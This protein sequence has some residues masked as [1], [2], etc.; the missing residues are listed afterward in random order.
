MQ[1][2]DG[3]IK[4]ENLNNKIWETAYVASILSDKTW[5]Q[6]MQK[7]EK[8]VVTEIQQESIQ[9]EETKTMVVKKSP[10]AKVNNPNDNKIKLE[11]NQIG[12]RI[13]LLENELKNKEKIFN[14]IKKEKE[15]MDWK[16]N[17]EKFQ[18]RKETLN[19]EIQMLASIIDFKALARVWHENPKEMSTLTE[20]RSNFQLT[21]N[22]DKGEVLSRLINLLENKKDIHNAISSIK[23][24]EKEIKDTNLENSPSL[25]LEK[26]I[27]KSKDEISSLQEKVPMENKKIDKLV[28]ARTPIIDRITQNVNLF[29][30]NIRI[31]F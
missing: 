7:F 21:F 8:P 17:M 31:T 20:Y 5:N 12:K 22:K 26:E 4:N 16:Q 18:K 27:Q 1:D 2:T 14:E 9:K 25:Y 11:I 15:Y 19:K 23:N 28:L 3:G 24:L 10:I 30:P 6:I 29:N 13:S